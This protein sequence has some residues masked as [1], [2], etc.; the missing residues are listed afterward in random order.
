MKTVTY[1]DA[2]IQ[3]L[4]D[5]GW[6]ETAEK[7][8]VWLRPEMNARYGGN[9]TGEALRQQDKLDI[10]AKYGAFFYA[11]PCCYGFGYWL[12]IYEGNLEKPR[13]YGYGFDHLTEEDAKKLVK[14]FNSTCDREA[15]LGIDYQ[16]QKFQ[17]IVIFHEKHGDRHFIVNTMQELEKVAL[18]IVLERNEEGWYS[19]DYDQ[20]VEPKVSVEDAKK[21]GMASVVA[22]VER[23][24]SDYKYSKKQYEDGIRL[25]AA[26]DKIEENKDGAVA[27]QFLN[28]MKDG[29]YEAFEVI[30]GEVLE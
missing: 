8:G 13:R 2:E 10:I 23:E 24:W 27:L 7:S 21:L 16:P 15:I 1:S 5:G 29:E 3:R 26:L 19:F 17:S 11:Q 6:K 30:S 4:I 12:G 9:S 25:K 20:P 22:A 28:S 14:S 18:K